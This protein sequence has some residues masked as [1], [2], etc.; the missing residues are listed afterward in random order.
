MQFADLCQYSLGNLHSR[1][2][3]R[4]G[5]LRCFDKQPQ[6]GRIRNQ[7][8]FAGLDGVGQAFTGKHFIFQNAEAAAVEGEGAG[9]SE[10]EPT[11]R[12]AG[13]GCATPQRDLFCFNFGLGNRDKSRL[14][15]LQRYAVLELVLEK[16]AEILPARGGFAHLMSRF[17]TGDGWNRR[18]RSRHGKGA[19]TNASA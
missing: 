8:S 12:A 9:V 16:V 14:V 18:R 19:A 4:L 2:M 11:Q 15:F 7:P 10:P 13:H 6:V 5:V 3:L 17:Q 1:D